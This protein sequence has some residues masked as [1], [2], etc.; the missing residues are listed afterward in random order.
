[1]KYGFNVKMVDTDT[2]E[3]EWQGSAD[4][5]LS[6][7]AEDALVLEVLDTLDQKDA[8]TTGNCGFFLLV[9]VD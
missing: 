9:R 4:D 2:R 6:A 7:N 3:T 5:L 1:M 8:G